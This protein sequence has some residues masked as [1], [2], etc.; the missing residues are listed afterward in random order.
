MSRSIVNKWELGEREPGAAS[1]RKLERVLL[2]DTRRD[3]PLSQATDMQ[4]IAE[5]ARRLAGHA[6]PPALP[7]QD[8]EWPRRTDPHPGHIGHEA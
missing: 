8:L 5:L 2:G 4:L 1:I 3:T 7:E 6:K